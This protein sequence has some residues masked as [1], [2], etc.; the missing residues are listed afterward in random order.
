MQHTFQRALQYHQAG[1]LA[2]AEALYRQ[3]LRAQPG[4]AQAL[5]LLGLAAYQRGDFVLAIAE[6]GKAI[7][8]LPRQSDYHNNLGLALRAH[9]QP[10]QAVE[11]YRRALQLAPG[12]A[13]IHNN[14]GSALHM[15]GLLNEAAASYHA[16]L[17]LQPSA[18]TRFN[19]G[20]VLYDQ[21]AFEQAA[22]C[23]REAQ[24]GMPGDADIHNNLGNALRELGRFD[25]A[26]ASYREALRLQPDYPAASRHLGWLMQEL[27]RAEEAVAWYRQARRTDASDAAACYNLGNALRELGRFDEA[28][29][30]FRDAV[31]LAPDD[32]DI[33]NN[34]GNVLRELGR[35]QEAIA[36]YREALRLNPQLHHAR[37]HLLHQC[38]HACDWSDLN[39][40]SEQV[41]AL[42]REEP[43]AQISP[44]AMLAVPGT[45]AA[46]Q[47]R[48][49]ENWS[50]G[51]YGKYRAIGDKL[52]FTFR[53]K[54]GPK[55]RLGYLSADF[56]EH[57]TAYL[58]AEVFELHDR[59]AFEIT[60]YSYGPDDA[61][62]MRVRLGKAFD[63]FEDIRALTAEEAARRIHR[64]AIDIL[65]DLKGYTAH[66]RSQILALRPAPVQINYLGYPGT[67]GAPFVDYLIGDPVVTPPEHA[68]HYTEQLAL[69]PHAYQPNDRR[70][71]LDSVPTRAACGLP[72]NAFVFCGFNQAFKILPEVFDVWMRLLR[73][74]PGSVLWLLQANTLAEG[75]L[76]REAQKRGV[77]SERLVFAP[78]LPLAQHLARQQLADLL[79]DTLPYNA[80]TTASDAL[81]SGVLVVTCIGDTF[82]GRVAASLL[83]A[84]GLPELITESMEQYARLALRLA[85]H[86]QQ[87]HGLRSKLR[88]QR[89]TAPLFD[90]EAF[91]R[92][93]EQLYRRMWARWLQGQPPE[94]MEP[95][96]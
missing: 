10:R 33:H 27:G 54:P 67:M 70:R 20:N 49:A 32:A 88:E 48:C 85:Q 51:Q 21:G 80:H 4:N 91:T 5:H 62:P 1:Q 36:C 46:E 56:H 34:L 40:L 75:N 6:I 12:D 43:E 68:I 61:G 41:R 47:R 81:W 83:H 7:A 25:E 82:A 60:A 38:Q 13:D 35:L 53:R 31:R 74:V 79:L 23:F 69:L 87:L 57:A 63:R 19:L 55:I 52:A 78:R 30:C 66:T 39:L 65:I 24:R 15:L 37:A 42:V 59:G 58:M 90:T 50:A 84:V 76:R 93:L 96:R 73:E 17:R 9:G 26:A 3:I 71:P 92:D 16:A 29:T 44:F 86:P 72:E 94:L 64:D 77:D 18:A 22:Q 8:I 2:Q 14:L 45:T 95:G 89:T 28:L 11:A